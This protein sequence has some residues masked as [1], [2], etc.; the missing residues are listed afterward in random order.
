MKHLGLSLTIALALAGCDD[1]KPK[2]VAS[3]AAQTAAAPGAA[4]AA[5]ATP[6][7]E[8]VA[9]CEQVMKH[10]EALAEKNNAAQA[11]YIKKQHAQEVEYCALHIDDK[12]AD[13]MLAATTYRV[14]EACRPP[15]N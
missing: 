13:C 8:R 5:K 1:P 11:E 4:P 7:P 12:A 9:R 15:L 6:K 3:S 14:A 2:A 10:I